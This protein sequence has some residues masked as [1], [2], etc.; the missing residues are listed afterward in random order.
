ML[1]GTG[2]CQFEDIIIGEAVVLYNP[3]EYIGRVNDKIIICES[4]TPDIYLLIHQAKLV[5]TEKGG[6]VCHVAVLANELGKPCVVGVNDIT[7]KI[8]TGQM[9]KVVGHDRKGEIYAY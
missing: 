6:L 2:D 3:M 7:K 4:P 8:H 9:I 5:I 1:L